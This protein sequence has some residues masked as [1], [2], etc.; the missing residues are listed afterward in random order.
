MTRRYSKSAGTKDKKAMH[1]R[2]RGTLKSGR[3]G[4]A[5]SFA[6]MRKKEQLPSGYVACLFAAI[7][8]FEMLPYH[9]EL[10]S[11]LSLGFRSL[12]RFSGSSASGP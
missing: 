1:E 2:K 7:C 12:C 9:E 3:W 11:E 10:V 5:A 6:L 8:L 4:E